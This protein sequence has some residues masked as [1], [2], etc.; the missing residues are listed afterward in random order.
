M[1][2]YFLFL[3]SIFLSITAFGADKYKVNVS[4]S[5]NVRSAPAKDAAILGSVYKGDVVEVNQISNGWAQISYKG[6]KA[7]ISSSYLV[8][9]TSVVKGKTK[10]TSMAWF[11]KVKSWFSWR[12]SHNLFNAI[13]SWGFF[14]YIILYFLMPII[15][16][17]IFVTVPTTILALFRVMP[18]WVFLIVA[19]IM[20]FNIVMAVGGWL[21]SHQA[22]SG[23][24]APIWTGGLLA[25][26]TYR[27]IVDIKRSRCPNCHELDS[28]ITRS[29]LYSTT[30]KTKTDYYYNGSYLDSETSTK[31]DSYRNDLHECRRCG[32]EWWTQTTDT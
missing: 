11:N 25:Y 32:Q 27:I 28:F 23:T 17:F 19:F 3:F 14:G 8:P 7:Y 24:F 5:L 1:K 10:D 18:N 15:I 31:T 22:Y 16:T 2:I 4:S 12:W 30:Y 29:K 21:L 13:Y 6:N 9:V 26:L 20:E